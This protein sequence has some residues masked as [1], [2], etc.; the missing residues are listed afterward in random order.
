MEQMALQA[1]AL[2]SGSK[3]KLVEVGA[4]VPTPVSMRTHIEN[5][6]P[7]HI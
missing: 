6:P 5:N 3:D 7:C 2:R 4:C 1:R